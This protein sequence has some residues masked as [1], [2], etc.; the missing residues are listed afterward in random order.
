MRGIETIVHK[1]KEIICVDLSDLTVENKAQGIQ[2]L[3]EASKKVAV[4]PQKSVLIITNVTNLGFDTEVSNAFRKYASDNTPY[5]KASAIVGLSGLQKVMFSAIK[6]LTGRDYY[7]A[8]DIEDA[9]NW[10]VS[11]G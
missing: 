10:L 11:A 5:V 9:K 7:L 4:N 6:T 8:R 2:T 1:G 3:R